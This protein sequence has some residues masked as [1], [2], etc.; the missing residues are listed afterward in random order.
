MSNAGRIGVSRYDVVIVGAGSAGCV[1]AHR[2]SAD[3]AV[4]VLLL[5]AGPPDRKMEIGIPAAFPKLFKT[6]YDWDYSTTVQRELADRSLYWPRG[7]TLGGSSSINAQMYVR[8]NAADYDAW[9]AAGN[10]GWSWPEVLPA[11]R[12]SECNSRGGNEFH[13]VDGPLSVEDL[14]DPSPLTR[15]FLRAAEQSGIKPNPDLNGEFQEG[16]SLSQVTQRRG[17]RASTS[18]AFLD[19]IR[20]RKNLTVR[21]GVQVRRIRFEG[22]RAVGVEYRDIGTDVVEAGEVIVSGGAINSPQLLMTSGVG[23]RADLEALGIP[24]VRDLPAVGRHLQDHLSVPV[25]ATIRGEGSLLAAEKPV[26]LVRYLLARKGMLTSNVGE[27]MAFVRSSPELDAPDLQLIFAPVEFIEHGLAPP[28]GHGVTCGVVLL[29]PR[30]EGEISLTTADPLAPARIEPRYLSDPGANDLRVLVA[31]VRLAREILG[32]PALADA[33][34]AEMWPGAEAGSDDDLAEFV[35][36]RAETLYHPVGT[37][38]MGPDAADSVV[39][40]TLRV[41][42]I[43]GLRVV[44]ASVMPG[45]VRGNT[46]APTIMIAERAAELVNAR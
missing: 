7:R 45:I 29:Q 46:N 40:P 34:D 42:G 15:A 3:P 1:L 39:D 22:T 8:G 25:I 12:R 24:V 11:F 37:C 9:A 6:E 17:K 43:D 27:A 13:G 23:P 33:V 14:R 35:R 28:P 36:R 26:E 19:P 41:H 38:R 20:R 31:G 32:A 5:E 21:T 16:V 10:S 44:D 4:S 18:R 30:S 2:L